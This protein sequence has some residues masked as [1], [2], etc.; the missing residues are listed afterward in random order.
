MKRSVGRP[1]TASAVTTALGP[2]IAVT[3]TPRS[4]AAA[5]RPY[6]GSLTVGMPASLST[7]M[8]SV[9]ASSA[10]SA[11]F[12]FSL[13]SCSAIRRGRF[14][15]PSPFSSRCVVRVSSAAMSVAF[16]STSTSRL[17]ASPRLPIGVAARMITRSA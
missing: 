4:A 8:S 9:S 14:A 11:A 13:W 3:V 16:S 1:D 7:T 15:I 5:T 17:D 6:P 10:S 12:A 2:G